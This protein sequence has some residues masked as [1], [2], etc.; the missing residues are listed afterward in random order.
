MGMKNQK[1]FKEFRGTRVYSPPDWILAG[2]YQADKLT[3]WSLGILLYDMLC[4]DIPFETDTE[5]LGG[6]LIWWEEL[7]LSS[8][9]KD[10]VTK[11]LARDQAL[12]LSLVELLAHPWLKDGAPLTS[13]MNE[14]IRRN[15]RS[16]N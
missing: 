5:I 3:V 8:L 15:K 4:G 14:G 9:A 10:L 2:E 1:V 16:F 7:S 13:K 12:R 6:R 11:C